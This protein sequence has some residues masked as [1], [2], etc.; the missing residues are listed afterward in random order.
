[1]RNCIS[2]SKRMFLLYR[3]ND[4]RNTLYKKRKFRNKFNQDE[5]LRRNLA[6]HVS[7]DFVTKKNFSKIYH[8]NSFQI[9]LR[10][11]EQK[12]QFAK[13]IV[14]QAYYSKLKNMFTFVL[15]VNACVFIIINHITNLIIFR[16]IT[17]T[18]FIL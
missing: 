14:D 3:N 4:V 15:I 1:M 16:Q 7:N 11:F 8:D 18:H 13:N 17:K 2:Y 6:V 12:L 10:T 5:L 9:N